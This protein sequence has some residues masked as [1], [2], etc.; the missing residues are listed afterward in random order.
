MNTKKLL[1]FLTKVGED[2]H[3]FRDFVAFASKY[4]FDLT[5]VSDKQLDAV[6]GGSDHGT[7][8]QVELAAWEAEAMQASLTNQRQAYTNALASMTECYDRRLDEDRIIG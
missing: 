6:A 1:E 2:D 8:K 7:E 4:G 3:M 5:E